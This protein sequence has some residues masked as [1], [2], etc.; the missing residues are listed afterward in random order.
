MKSCKEITASKAATSAAEIS[1][2]VVGA[3]PT[4]VEVCRKLAAP[5]VCPGG[6]CRRYY[7][8]ALAILASRSAQMKQR[9]VTAAPLMALTAKS[10]QVEPVELL[11][12]SPADEV[13]EECL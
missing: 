13:T 7:R 5:P 2:A 1:P 3:G 8:R 4:S 6:F 12:V 11:V 9:S 10:A